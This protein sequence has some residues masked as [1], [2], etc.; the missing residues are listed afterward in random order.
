GARRRH[1]GDRDGDGRSRRDRAR[2]RERPARAAGRRVRVRRCAAAVPR[3]RGAARAAARG[4]C[5]VRRALRAGAGPAAARGDPRGRGTV[6]PRVLFVGRT[7]YRLPLDPALARKWDAL[8]EELDVRVLA[9]RRDGS[10]G[11]DPRF[12]LL[13]DRP[14]AAFYASLPLAM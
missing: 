3:R 11:S 4:G 7:R 9:T 12:T 10:S 2:R 13:P 5:G 1:A 8:S 14:L 6:K